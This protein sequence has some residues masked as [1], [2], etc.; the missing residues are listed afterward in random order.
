[1][2]MAAGRGFRFRL[3]AQPHQICKTARLSGHGDS[4]PRQSFRSKLGLSAAT[5]PRQ[6]TAAVPAEVRHSLLKKDTAPDPTPAFSLQSTRAEG[7]AER[8]R[9]VRRRPL[10]AIRVERRAGTLALK[11]EEGA[12][13]AAAG[14][15]AL[16]PSHQLATHLSP[17]SPQWQGHSLSCVCGQTTGN[18]DDLASASEPGT[19]APVDP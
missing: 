11:R 6:T 9:S 17:R 19:S 10:T 13:Q 14:A 8:S 2:R 1:T 3:H 18:V 5:R 16:E 7:Q 4:A 15:V 12:R